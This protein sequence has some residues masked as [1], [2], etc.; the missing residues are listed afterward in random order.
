[1]APRASLPYAYPSC[2]FFTPLRLLA[3][4]QQ[5]ALLPGWH[6]Y[7]RA[8]RRYVGCTALPGPIPIT[9]LAEGAQ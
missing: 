8:K 1:M 6:T 3:L 9:V 5:A 2:R 4:R 7:V